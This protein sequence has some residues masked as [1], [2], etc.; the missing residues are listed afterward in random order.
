MKSTVCALNVELEEVNKML[1]E[2]TPLVS[3][4]TQLYKIKSI[5]K[6]LP[7]LDTDIYYVMDHSVMPKAPPE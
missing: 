5:H 3:L 4:V 7:S 1:Q 6:K 2:N